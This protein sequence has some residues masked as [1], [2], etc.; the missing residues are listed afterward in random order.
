MPRAK[1]DECY[2]DGT[3]CS[4]DVL[5]VGFQ[6]SSGQIVAFCVDIRL[7]STG[8]PI[9]PS[10]VE[11][12]AVG[13]RS[14]KM[15]GRRDVGRF[16]IDASLTHSSFVKNYWKAVKWPFQF[17]DCFIIPF[18]TTYRVD[19]YLY[20]EVKLKSAVDTVTR[21]FKLSYYE[22]IHFSL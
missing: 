9:D 21:A 13:Y 17:E 4:T 12:F 6:F 3:R 14:T 5:E 16:Q 7:A 2:Y 10:L 19:G 11:A 22:H 8:L 20:I 1:G 18:K 15:K